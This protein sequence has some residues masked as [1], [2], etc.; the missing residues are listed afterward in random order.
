V[1]VVAEKPSGKSDDD[2][3]ADVADGEDV[4][5]DVGREEEEEERVAA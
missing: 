3:G 4:D 5:G 2:D 1:L